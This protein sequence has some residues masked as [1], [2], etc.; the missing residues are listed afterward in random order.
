MP[1]A[2]LKALFMKAGTI[3]T[4]HGQN[5]L[6]TGPYLLAYLALFLVGT[7]NQFFVLYPLYLKEC[8]KDDLHIG[9]LMGMNALGAF[10]ARPMVGNLL[11]RYGRRFFIVSGSLAASIS[12]ILYTVPSTSD[13]YLAALRFCHGLFYAVFFTG[14]FTWV[15]DYSPGQRLAEGIGI[16]GTAGLSS[17]ASGPYLGEHVLMFSHGDYRLFYLAAV[18]LTLGGCGAASLLK[19]CRKS[20]GEPGVGFF[21]LLRRA[22]IL[23]AVFG[24]ILFGAGTGVTSN[25]MAAY[26]RSINMA[27]VSGFF[28]CYALASV[29]TRLFAGRGADRLGRVTLAVPGLILLGVGQIMLVS[30]EDIPWLYLVGLLMGCGHGI[31][32]PALN[33]LTLE[34]AGRNDRGAG[35]A[36]FNASSDAGYSGGSILF[37]S[38]AGRTDYGTTFRLSG[39]TL[40]A[41]IMIFAAVEWILCRICRDNRPSGA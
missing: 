40:L 11:D 2:A 16:L 21:G 8:G 31:V 7:G 39:I 37:G 36:L 5:F 23:A 18:V 34:R 33:A 35:S 22:D 29:V 6:F 9:F 14:I 12:I 20:A 30:R 32:Y 25:F 38:I 10:L 17:I 15:A 41:G 24:S 27:S 28:V 1:P 26:A 13:A 4:E 19:D 3:S